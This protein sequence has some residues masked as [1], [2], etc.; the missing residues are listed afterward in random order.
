MPTGSA[1]AFHTAGIRP[2]FER[3]LADAGRRAKSLGESNCFMGNLF[4]DL[5]PLSQSQSF[6]F[7]P[8]QGEYT[9]WGG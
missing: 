4:I 3:G 1:G 2:A 6:Y 7:D 5:R 9:L 8:K